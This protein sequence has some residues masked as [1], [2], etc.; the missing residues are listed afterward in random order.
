MV[1]RVP[2]AANNESMRDAPVIRPRKDPVMAEKTIQLDTTGMHCQS[3]AM[4]IDMSV[5]DLDGVS[6]V[7]SDYAAGTTDVT[8]DDEKVSVD[9]IVDEIAKAGYGATPTRG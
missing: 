8:F 9:R 6:E 7:H 4:L 3:C 5:G 1:C 2:R